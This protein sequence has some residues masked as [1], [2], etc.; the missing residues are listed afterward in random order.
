METENTFQKTSKGF[1]ERTELHV[2]Y[3]HG[4]FALKRERHTHLTPMIFSG[5]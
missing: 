2:N 4:P 5:R 3:R 1:R